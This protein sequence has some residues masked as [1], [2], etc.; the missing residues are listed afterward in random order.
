MRHWAYGGRLCISQAC[1]AYLW[2]HWRASGSIDERGVHMEDC[3][4]EVCVSIGPCSCA[5]Q[6][7]PL[8]ATQE[9]DVLHHVRNALLLWALIHTT[10][11]A[12]AHRASALSGGTTPMAATIRMAGTTSSFISL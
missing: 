5:Q 1:V 10:C 4:V 2:Q 8:L 12:Q 9:G 6:L 11:A 7:L 3:V